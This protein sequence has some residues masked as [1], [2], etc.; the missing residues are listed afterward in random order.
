MVG[1]VMW[2]KNR[3]STGSGNRFKVEVEHIKV[4]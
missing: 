4:P 1:G 3:L 2:A